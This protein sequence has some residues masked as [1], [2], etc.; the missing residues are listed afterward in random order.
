MKKLIT[1]EQLN[2]FL[3]L[4]EKLNNNPPKVITGE[5]FAAINFP[6]NEDALF[7]ISIQ[8]PYDDR[9]VKI[10]TANNFEDCLYKFEEFITPIEEVIYTAEFVYNSNSSHTTK[11][12]TVEVVKETDSSIEGYEDGSYKKFLKDRIVGG[13]ILRKD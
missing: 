13:R 10:F 11:W 5:F 9:A 7:S 4:R 2:R 8:D 6:S 12:R 3:E 1:T